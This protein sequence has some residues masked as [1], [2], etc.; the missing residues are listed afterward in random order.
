MVTGSIASSLH[1]EPRLT[2][3]IDMIIDIEPRSADVFLQ[4]FQPPTFYL[5][6]TAIND[7]IRNRSMFN[8][9]DINSGNKVDFWILTPEAFD[10]SRFSRRQLQAVEGANQRF[11]CRRHD[12]S[13]AAMGGAVWW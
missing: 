10:Q 8:L 2:H 6:A 11:Y 7:A 9:L 4:A 12:P 5:S 1:G 3:D 13:Q